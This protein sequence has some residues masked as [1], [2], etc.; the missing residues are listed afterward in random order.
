MEDYLNLKY[1]IEPVYLQNGM[2]YT[3][4]NFQ[5]L[6]ESHTELFN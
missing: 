6:K 2:K 4:D 3:Y 1:N 5:L